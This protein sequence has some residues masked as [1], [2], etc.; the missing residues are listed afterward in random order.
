MKRILACFVFLVTIAAFAPSVRADEWVCHGKSSQ[1]AMWWS[2][3]H[4]GVGEWY[5]KGFGDFEKAPQK[6]FWLG[7]IPLYGWPGYLQVLSAIDAYH[8]R[9]SDN[10]EPID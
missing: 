9:T 2:I 4:P 10:L 8:G 1:G 6:K 3:L 7:F 5:L